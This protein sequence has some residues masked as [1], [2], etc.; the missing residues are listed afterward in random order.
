M[1]APIN[2][3][4]IAILLDKFTYNPDTGKLYH[5]KS[6][7]NFIKA[8]D[9]V[10]Y[11]RKDGYLQ[12][13]VNSKAFLVHRV[14]YYMHTGE[15]PVYID[16]LNRDRADNRFVNFSSGTHHED[17]KNKS[18]YSNN[19]TGERL[20]SWHKRDKVYEVKVRVNGV[21]HYIGRNKTL[22]G[23]IL[24]RDSSD[25]IKSLKLHNR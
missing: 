23:A 15:Q 19:E 13:K 8:G 18:D 11:L 17:M 5:N 10:G 20:I 6:Y 7:S 1:V 9:E 14:C 22:S 12:C 25:L 4:D 21:Q 24:L 16:H 2:L 3:P